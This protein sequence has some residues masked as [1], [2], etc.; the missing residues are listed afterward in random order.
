MSRHK[1]PDDYSEDE[2]ALRRD[3]VMKRMLQTPPKR[4][5]EMKVGKTK[6]KPRDRAKPKSA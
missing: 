3:E 6:P 5:D 4:H 2:A 1:L